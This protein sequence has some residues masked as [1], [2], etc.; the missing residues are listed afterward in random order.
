VVKV[1][2]D[3]KLRIKEDDKEEISKECTIAKT[4]SKIMT[5]EKEKTN[6]ELPDLYPFTLRRK[7]DARDEVGQHHPSILGDITVNARSLI[8]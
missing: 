8:S 7:D 6:N 1:H 5:E 3:K 4:R 2:H